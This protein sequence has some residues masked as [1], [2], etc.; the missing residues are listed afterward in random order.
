M[1]GGDINRIIGGFYFE[2]MKGYSQRRMNILV[3]YIIFL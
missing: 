2:Y 1:S 3:E